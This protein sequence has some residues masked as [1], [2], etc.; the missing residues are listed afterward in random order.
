[1]L[2]VRITCEDSYRLHCG[3]GWECRTF[4]L[5]KAKETPLLSTTKLLARI[6]AP[7][8]LVFAAAALKGVT[9]CAVNLH[10]LRELVQLGQLADSLHYH[11]GFISL[12]AV[13]FFFSFAQFSQIRLALAH[14]STVSKTLIVAVC[15]YTSCD[16]KT[17]QVESNDTAKK[18]EELFVMLHIKWNTEKLLS[19]RNETVS[20]S[21][22][23]FL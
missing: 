13:F 12:V 22:S 15:C 11:L 19:L 8:A 14:H 20:W 17:Y 4:I 10:K 7:Y 5:N 9:E 21:R 1:M 3:Q 23:C 2:Y 18:Q 6:R 16:G